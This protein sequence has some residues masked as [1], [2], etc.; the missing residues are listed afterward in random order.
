MKKM[1]KFKFIIFNSN[2]TLLSLV[3]TN[4]WHIYQ[5]DVKLNFIS[6]N[7]KEKIN[8]KIPSEQDKSKKYIWQC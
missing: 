5:I 7:P 1:K 4:S 2:K 6:G 3:C 8:I